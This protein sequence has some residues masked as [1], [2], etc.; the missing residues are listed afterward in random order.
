MVLFIVVSN[1]ELKFDFFSIIFV[2][3][4]VFYDGLLYDNS[5]IF[6]MLCF[7]GLLL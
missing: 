5:V 4:L 1:G 6:F 2:H 7:G 3:I